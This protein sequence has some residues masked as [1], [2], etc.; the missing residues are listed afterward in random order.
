L[1]QAG[2][3]SPTWADQPGAVYGPVGSDHDEES[4]LDVSR[5]LAAVFRFRWLVVLA[6]I[7]GA[8]GGGV[9]WSRTDLEYVAGA[10]LWI[11]AS[12]R[13]APNQGPITG[14]QLLTSTS[15]IELLR[16][17][18]VLNTVVID[19]R[20]YLTV[21]DT[22]VRPAFASF[23]IDEAFVP[24]DYELQ[25]SPSTQ[26]VTL[27][28]DGLTV[29][30]KV[31]G[32]KLGTV[33]GFDWTPTI[34]ALAPEK[35]IAFS[36]AR[37]WVVAEGVRGNLVAQMDRNGTFIWVELRGKDA[38][39][40][41]ATLNAILDQHVELAAEL[42]SAALEERTSVLEGQLAT[43]E[44]ELES[45]ERALELFRKVVLASASIPVGFP[46]VYIQVEVDGERYDEMHVEGE[47]FVVVGA[48]VGWGF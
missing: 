33:V 3:P 20:L 37:P 45:S 39:E 44:S 19:T 25:Y 7:L 26:T 24:G 11:Q 14:S 17:F 32:E 8:V 18:A 46:P 2:L 4:G 48:S 36:V 5:L 12:D 16:S 9:A 10:S 34:E 40:V 1:E 27:F 22:T 6:T 30:S 38:A 23:R 13:G 21:P 29:E 15:W 31:L 42:K 28:R 41:A 43:V 47:Q 35:R